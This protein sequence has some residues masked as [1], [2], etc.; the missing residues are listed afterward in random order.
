MNY[1][2]EC[3]VS[4][5][6]QGSEGMGMKKVSEVYLLDALSFT[7][8]EERVIKEVQ[9]FVSIGDLE[10]VNIKRVKLAEV[11]YNDRE[12]ADR[13]YRARVNFI[14]IDEKSGTE[15]KTAVNMLI[16]SPSLPEA[17]SILSSEM[18]KQLG[19]YEISSITDTQIL[20]IFPYVAPDK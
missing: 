12:E 18:E 3:K 6:R 15:K 10:V 5:E 16:Q 13:Y 20:D 17:V 2:F 1:W 4:Y 11:F 14:T 9:P 7:E 8:A 19:E